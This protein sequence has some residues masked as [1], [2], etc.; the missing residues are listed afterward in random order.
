MIRPIEL[1]DDASWD[2]F[3]AASDGDLSRVKEL[4]RQRPG[5]A[6]PEYNYTPPLH[7]AEGHREIVEFLVGQGAPDGRLF[8]PHRQR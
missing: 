5:L 2:M 4:A 6:V 8:R 7:F 1:R 3:Q